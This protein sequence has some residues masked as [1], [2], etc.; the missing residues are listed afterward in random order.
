MIKKKLF[1]YGSVFMCAALMACSLAACGTNSARTES[2]TAVS[3][4]AANDNDSILSNAL[5]NTLYSASQTTSK[6]VSTEKKTNS[7]DET[8]YVFTD[9]TG[10]QDHLIVNEKLNNVTGVS[11]IQ[12]VSKLSNIK[13]LTGDET[14]TSG[15]DGK[16]TWAADGN[17]I[18]YQ[19]TSTQQ[20]PVTIKV[21]YYLDGKEISADK[22]L[23]QSGKVKIRFDYTNNEKKTITVNGK[24]QTAY[25]P[26]TML[27]GMVLPKDKFSNI[28]VTNGKVTQVN[29]NNIVIGAAMP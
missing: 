7:K 13:N 10:K 11:T 25:V 27:T 3:A 9:V 2:A 8:V 29:D 21:T 24:T 22:L 19:G 23:G 6:N 16:L 4:A 17:S 12:D 26:F 28:E 1:K 5:S 18:T 20:T 15:S 14:S